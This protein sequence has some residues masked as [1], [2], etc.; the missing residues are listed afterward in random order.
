MTDKKA[1]KLLPGLLSVTFRSHTAAE[2]VKLATEAK[3]G[4][5]EWG[6]D[7]H[8]PGGNL[9]AARRVR[10]LC[11]DCGLAISAFGSYLRAGVKAAENLSCTAVLDSAAELGTKVVRVWAGVRGSAEASREDRDAVVDGLAELCD[12]SAPRGMQIATEF[13]GGTLTDDIDSCLTILK[14]VNR[15][16][17]RTFWQPPN[18]MPREPAVAGLRRIGHQLAHVHVFHWW[19]DDLHRRPLSE[20]AVRW[21]VYLREVAEQCERDG[22]QRYASLEFVKDGSPEQ[23]RCDAETLHEWLREI[24]V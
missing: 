9:D 2:I 7:I 8:V 20:G 14:E 11:E 21:R 16:N 13:H 5:I 3:L 12:L 18:G 23:F 1:G 15:P 17:L 24:A 4:A 19:P 10:R 6:G 22:E